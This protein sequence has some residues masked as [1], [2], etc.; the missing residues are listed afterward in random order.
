M[1]SNLI[2]TINFINTKTDYLDGS[3]FRTFI[4]GDLKVVEEDLAISPPANQN[5]Y[6]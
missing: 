1:C 6:P 3:F 4:N 5:F 2:E